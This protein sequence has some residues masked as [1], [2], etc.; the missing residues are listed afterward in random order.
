M[1]KPVLSTS[2]N[3]E[4]Y[5]KLEEYCRK[6]NKTKSEVVEEALRKFLGIK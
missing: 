4:V 1:A 6:N 3:L 2:I 5:L